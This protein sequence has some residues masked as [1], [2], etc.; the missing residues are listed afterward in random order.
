MTLV[1]L[2]RNQKTNPQVL[3]QMFYRIKIKDYFSML[4]LYIDKDF[5][6]KR[7][8]QVLRFSDA[9]SDYHYKRTDEVPRV[10]PD[11]TIGEMLH[12]AMNLLKSDCNEID[13]SEYEKLKSTAH[14]I[15]KSLIVYPFYDLFMY[16]R[17]DYKGYEIKKRILNENPV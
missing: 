1:Q 2:K 10:N 15:I 16:N 17:S 7:Y 3:Q 12:I 11:A 6:D 9:D 4:S 13:D 8:E 14:Q 5:Y